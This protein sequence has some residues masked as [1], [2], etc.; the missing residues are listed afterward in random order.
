MASW[1]N[2]LIHNTTGLWNAMREGRFSLRRMWKSR[3]EWF[4]QKTW[5]MSP[6]TAE[7]W[8]PTVPELC[9]YL[10]LL[11]HDFESLCFWFCFFNSLGY[12]NVHPINLLINQSL[13]HYLQL[14]NNSISNPD[15]RW[16]DRSVY[17]FLHSGIHFI[18]TA[19]YRCRPLLPIIEK[20]LVSPCSAYPAYYCQGG[21]LK[22]RLIM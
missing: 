6:R 22:S 20:V 16:C 13:F 15:L 9:V 12:P 14:K 11:K 19:P 3:R 2:W 18:S 5:A 7:C 17:Q 4:K 10:S 1:R 8:M 21:L